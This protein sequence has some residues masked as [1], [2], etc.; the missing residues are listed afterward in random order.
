MIGTISRPILDPSGSS[1]RPPKIPRVPQVPYRTHPCNVALNFDGL[2][3]FI[4]SRVPC[5]MIMLVCRTD[6]YNH[7]HRLAPTMQYVL[8]VS[9]TARPWQAHTTR[10]MSL[11]ASPR[12]TVQDDPNGANYG[13]AGMAKLSSGSPG[14]PLMTTQQLI[15]A[16]EPHL[17]M[18]VS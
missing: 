18:S 11:R 15:L 10:C 1:V 13:Q 16:H 14:I 8:R 2:M 17:Y 12:A 7:H 4:E 3:L 5:A 6:I 9:T